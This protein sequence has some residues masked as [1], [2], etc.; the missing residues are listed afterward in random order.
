ML[1]SGAINLVNNV[2]KINEL[3]YFPVPDN[4]TGTN[5]KITILG[6]IEKIENANFTSFSEL[7]KSFC[8]GIMYE[9][10]GNSGNILCAIFQGF[11]EVIN[12]C[13]EEISFEK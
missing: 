10:R 3:N 8:E 6:G 12:T 11:F 9:S 5:M 2:S 13:N 7:G 1:K 4:D